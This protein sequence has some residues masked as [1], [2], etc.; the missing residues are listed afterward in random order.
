M[1]APA[2]LTADFT[3]MSVWS[4]FSGKSAQIEKWRLQLERS[5][6]KTM[7]DLTQKTQTEA[8]SIAFPYLGA[9]IMMSENSQNE[10]LRIMGNCGLVFKPEVK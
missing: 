7:G 1:G 10:V 5:G 9:A 4:F 8:F 3:K 2:N 6:I